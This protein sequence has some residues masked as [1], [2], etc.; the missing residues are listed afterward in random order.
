MPVAQAATIASATKA[1]SPKPERVIRSSPV[2]A[3]VRH[4]LSFPNGGT[5]YD[6]PDVPRAARRRGARRRRRAV[7][8]RTRGV[9]AE[10]RAARTPAAAERGTGRRGDLAAWGRQHA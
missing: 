10:R 3:Y 4:A 5:C 6:A 9:H 1:L 8:L 7:R 2:V